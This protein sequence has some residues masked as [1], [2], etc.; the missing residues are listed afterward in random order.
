MTMKRVILQGPDFCALTE[1][2][3]LCE[4]IPDRG[5]GEETEAILTGRVERIMAGLKSAFVDIG[6]SRSG[7]LPLEENS[8]SL[9]S[10]ERFTR[11]PLWLFLMNPPRLS[12][13]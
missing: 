11:I 10:R 12:T 3:Y 8:K 6:R 7:F 9:P 1:D 5:Q 4:Y 13:R 2:G